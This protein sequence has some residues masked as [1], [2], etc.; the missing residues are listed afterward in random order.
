MALRQAE[1][2]VFEI[3]FLNSCREPKKVTEGSY[4]QTLEVI[5]KNELWICKLWF[6]F[7][8]RFNPLLLKLYDVSCWAKKSETHDRPYIFVLLKNNTKDCSI[9]LYSSEPIPVNFKTAL[10]VIRII[11]CVEQTIRAKWFASPSPSSLFNVLLIPGSEG[12]QY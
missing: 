10:F 1:N 9:R 2:F 7:C 6:D 4:F 8:S 3:F 11:T 5:L 12:L